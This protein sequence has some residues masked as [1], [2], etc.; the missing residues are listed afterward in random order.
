MRSWQQLAFVV[1]SLSICLAGAE[2]PA[3]IGARVRL[4]GRCFNCH[5]IPETLLRLGQTLANMACLVAQGSRS[6]RR[7]MTGK[8]LWMSQI[9]GNQDAGWCSC[10]H[11]MGSEMETQCHFQHPSWRSS[12]G[13]NQQDP[14][15]PRYMVQSM[16]TCTASRLWQELTRPVHINMLVDKC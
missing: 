15:Q 12:Q 6:A 3:Y 5:S 1:L 11:Q 2:V 4:H 14:K 9:P 10:V 7:S 16:I 13:L 8:V